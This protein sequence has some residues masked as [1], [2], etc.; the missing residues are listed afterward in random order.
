MRRSRGW[1]SRLAR[2][3]TGAQSYMSHTRASCS[4]VASLLY[5]GDALYPHTPLTFN[6]ITL[7]TLGWELGHHR[8][9]VGGIFLPLP[10]LFLLSLPE[11]P[12]FLCCGRKPPPLHRAQQSED[13]AGAA[14]PSSQPHHRAASFS[15]MNLGTA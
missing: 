14:P 5:N 2:V 8:P 6:Q 12:D 11:L 1:G 7:N 15:Q 4:P 10:V 13:W 3:L 9:H